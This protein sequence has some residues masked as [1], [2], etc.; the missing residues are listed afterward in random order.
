MTKLRRILVLILAMGIVKTSFYYS[1]H[2]GEHAAKQLCQ[3][4]KICYLSNKYS[5]SF[6]FLDSLKNTYPK[7]HDRI[8]ENL[9]EK[10]CIDSV[11]QGLIETDSLLV[12]AM[13]GYQTL[14]SSVEEHHSDIALE[15]ALIKSG[16]LCDS[17]RTRTEVLTERKRKLQKETKPFRAENLAY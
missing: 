11:N 9:C 1:M 2:H 13:A 16:L 4:A 3:K 14:E 8:A 6:F 10:V 5:E 7:W 17:L 12:L 15:E